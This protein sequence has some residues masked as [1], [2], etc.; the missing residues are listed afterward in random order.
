MVLKRSDGFFGLD[1]DD[2]D[3]DDDDVSLLKLQGEKKS[4]SG[5]MV[6]FFEGVIWLIF[7]KAKFLQ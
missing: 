5:F 3:D 7:L 4:M 6:I 1:D 2:D